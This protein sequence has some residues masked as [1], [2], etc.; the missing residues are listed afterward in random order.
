MAIFYG[1]TELSKPVTR[2]VTSSYS[3]DIT[4]TSYTA[5][6]GHSV[7]L[8]PQSTDCKFLVVIE[9][10]GTMVTGSSNGGFEINR[11]DHTTTTT[12]QIHTGGAY[13]N[14][15][16][17]RALMPLFS[18]YLDSPATTNQ[19]TYSVNFRKHN[20]GGLGTDDFGVSGTITVFELES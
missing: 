5:V 14:P 16:G 12:T 6:T 15:G 8:T 9:S 2:M 18:L 11:Y 7:S 4:S 10:H 3:A 19:L 20:G 1:S 13:A 17:I